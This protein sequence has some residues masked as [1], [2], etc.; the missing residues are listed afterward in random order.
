MDN[1]RIYCTI[2][3]IFFSIPISIIFYIIMTVFKKI[4]KH[5]K[6]KKE[7]DNLTIL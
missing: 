6:K 1:N 7:N 2:N 5:Q 4:I 3:F